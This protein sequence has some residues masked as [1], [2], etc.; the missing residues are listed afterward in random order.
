MDEKISNSFNVLS[1]S[2]HIGIWNP[3]YSCAHY[4]PQRI[5]LIEYQPRIPIQQILMH[6]GAYEVVLCI[7][8]IESAG[9][10]LFGH[11]N[12]VQWKMHRC[13]TCVHLKVCILCCDAGLDK[14]FKK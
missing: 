6:M 13:N 9:M 12:Y 2:T 1:P 11:I 14:I 8:V 7:K 3:K 10:H 5:S 4:L